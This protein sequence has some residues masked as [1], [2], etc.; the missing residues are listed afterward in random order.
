MPTVPTSDARSSAT[1]GDPMVAAS[2]HVRDQVTS[3]AGHYLHWGVIQISLTNFL[4]IVGMVVVFI[5][6]LLLPFPGGHG[7]AAE[8]SRPD[9][10]D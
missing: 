2:T 7:D 10:R 5:L 3:A 9:D 4:I 6:A 1:A 8:Q